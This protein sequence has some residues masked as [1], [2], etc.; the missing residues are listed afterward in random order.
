MSQ[1]SGEQFEV[2]YTLRC[3]AASSHRKTY[4]GVYGGHEGVHV[5]SNSVETGFGSAGSQPFG[6]KCDEII[7]ATVSHQQG[8]SVFSCRLLCILTP[9][10]IDTTAASSSGNG[11][12]H[13]SVQQ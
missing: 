3:P 6:S 12:F 8:G 2:L 7:L 4:V 9:L 5:L 1:C 10:H 13:L 11:G